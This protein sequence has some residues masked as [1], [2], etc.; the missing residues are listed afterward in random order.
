MAFRR[1]PQICSRTRR[2]NLPQNIMDRMPLG[3]IDSAA[4]E[5]DGLVYVAPFP[6]TL[7]DVQVCLFCNGVELGFWAYR[8]HLG[9]DDEPTRMLMTSSSIAMGWIGDSFSPEISMASRLLSMPHVPNLTICPTT[10]TFYSATHSKAHN[11]L[12]NSHSAQ[13]FTLSTEQ[14]HSP[15]SHALF[16]AISNSNSSLPNL[17]SPLW[18]NS[19]LM[20]P[21]QPTILPF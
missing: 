13:H 11:T 16:I 5:L 8:F 7:A 9:I 10:L 21:N 12:H 2:R 1:L 17:R 6:C 3:T 20:M 18:L 15:M 4:S 19:A 14:C